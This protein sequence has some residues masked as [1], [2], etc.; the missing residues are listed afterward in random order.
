MAIG[1]LNAVAEDDAH[2]EE[3]KVDGCTDCVVW[4]QGLR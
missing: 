1:A 3:R 2:T 4:I